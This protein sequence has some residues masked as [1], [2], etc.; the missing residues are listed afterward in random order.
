MKRLVF[1][2]LLFFAMISLSEAEQKVVTLY[3]SVHWSGSSSYIESEC[4]AACPREGDINWY[5]QDGWI[6]VGT[7]PF[8]TQPYNYSD[9]QCRCTGIQYILQR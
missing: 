5:L 2:L 4:K 8:Q 9:R 1:S 7:Q 6:I 3:N